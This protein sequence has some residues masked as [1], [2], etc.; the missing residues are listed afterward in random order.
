MTFTDVIILIVVIGLLATIIYFSF[1][2]NKGKVHVHLVQALNQ[3]LLKNT[4]NV[5]VKEKN[6]NKLLSKDDSFF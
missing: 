6:S 2:K 3:V 5:N 1:I 4:I